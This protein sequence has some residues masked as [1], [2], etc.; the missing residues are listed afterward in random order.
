MPLIKDRD[1]KAFW[2]TAKRDGK[3]HECKEDIFEGDRIVFEPPY[4][5]YCSNCGEEIT[6]KGDHKP[7]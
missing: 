7:S 5:A 3:C 2:M 1:D 4:N 6:G